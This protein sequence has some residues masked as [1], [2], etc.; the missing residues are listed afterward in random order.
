MTYVKFV[1]ISDLKDTTLKYNGQRLM[2]FLEDE[3]V[4]STYDDESFK[5]PY[6]ETTPMMTSVKK[7]IWKIKLKRI[8][9]MHLFTKGRI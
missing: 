7:I 8:C 2:F 6:L 1:L 5:A 9:M 4:P 3:D